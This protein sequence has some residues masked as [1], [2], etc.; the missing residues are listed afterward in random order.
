MRRILN[1]SPRF[2]MVEPGQIDVD[3]SL[4]DK[5]MSWDAAH[6]I[7]K[8][9]GCQGIVA[10]E[11]FD[12]DSSID[13]REEQYKETEDGKEITKKRWHA[14]RQTNVLTAWRLYDVENRTVIDQL[15]DHSASE[16]WEH[17][18]ET[19]EQAIGSLPSQ[20]QSVRDMGARAGDHYGRR[21]APSYVQVTRAIYVRGDDRL[22]AQKNKAK[23]GQL[24]EAESAWKKVWKSGASDKVKARAAYN[25]AV[26][27][28]VAKVSRVSKLAMKI[29]PN[30][31]LSPRLMTISY[32]SQAKADVTGL[33]YTR[34]LPVDGWQRVSR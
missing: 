3:S 34:F 12:S 31:C 15:R 5:Q 17:T 14:S 33:K 20:T 1:E 29:S 30:I 9:A 7:C 16:T 26:S 25:L 21:I 28:E 4:F 11:A 6:R 8:A 2:E 13:T 18:A 24:K 23:A 10:L 27:K 22:K 19:E 32:S